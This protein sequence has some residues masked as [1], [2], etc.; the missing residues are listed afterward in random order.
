MLTIISDI[1]AHRC[2]SGT[3][4]P[5]PTRARP[6]PPPPPARSWLRPLLLLRRAPAAA[7][8]ACACEGANVGERGC[9]GRSRRTDSQIATLLCGHQSHLLVEKA[10]AGRCSGALA[11]CGSPPQRHC[12]SAPAPTTDDF[13]A[14]ARRQRAGGLGVVGLHTPCLP[15]SDLKPRLACQDTNRCNLPCYG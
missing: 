4:V 3:S 14:P 2:C 9:S 8:W 10:L 1:Q 15:E 13:I 7:A 6:A 11:R 5:P 12:C